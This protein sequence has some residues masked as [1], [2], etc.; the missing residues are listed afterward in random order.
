MIQEAI[1]RQLEE[2]VVDVLFVVVWVT[3]LWIVP[4]LTRMLDVLLE[5]IRML[6]RL[7]KVTGV[8][9]RCRK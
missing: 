9:G 6:L 7:V 2:S 5:G 1:R 4:R 8:I 3:V